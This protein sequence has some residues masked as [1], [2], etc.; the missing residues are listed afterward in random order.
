MENFHAAVVMVTLVTVFTRGIP[1]HTDIS[2]IAGSTRERK[3]SKSGECFV[4]GDVRT[5]PDF[6]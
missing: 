2:D 3:M 1:S 4:T 5:F 6:I